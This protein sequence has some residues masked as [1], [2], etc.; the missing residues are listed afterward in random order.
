MCDQVM[1]LLPFERLQPSPPFTNIC[2]DYFGPYEIRGEVQKR[3][4]DK[5]YG[6]ILTC[7]AVQAVYIDVASDFST[8]A[9]YQVLRRF[10]NLRGWPQSIFSGGVTQLVGASRELKEQLRGLDWKQIREY[11]HQ[12]GMEW[13]F[14]PG[15]APLYNGMAEALVKSI[16]RALEAAVGDTVLAFSELKTCMFEAEQLVNHRPIGVLSGT[17]DDGAYL[18]PKDLLLGRDSAH[19]PLGPFQERGSKKHRHDFIQAIIS[20]F[21]KRWSRE[22]FPNLVMQPK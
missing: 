18:C 7:I 5:C 2:I 11:G 19:I 15:D 13:K 3:I 6:V 12:Q 20:A 21:W 14:S 10:A 8:D 4:R 16:K 22:V 17:P 9:F 1:S